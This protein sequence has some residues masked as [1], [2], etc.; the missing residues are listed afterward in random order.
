M[1]NQRIEQRRFAAFE[2]TDTCYIELPLGNSLG[3]TAGRSGYVLCSQLSR[4]LC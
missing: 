1:P 3:D 2:L 4:Y